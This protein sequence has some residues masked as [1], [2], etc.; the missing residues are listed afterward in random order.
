MESMS[1]KLSESPR[2]SGISYRRI[3]T[4]TIW[5]ILRT[6][7]LL[8]LR[9]TASYSRTMSLLSTFASQRSLDASWYGPRGRY[10]SARYWNAAV[11]ARRNKTCSKEYGPRNDAASASQLSGNWPIN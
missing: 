9:R 10:I 2:K 5:A 11:R 3:Q 7:L 4:A 8:L 6:K 1:F